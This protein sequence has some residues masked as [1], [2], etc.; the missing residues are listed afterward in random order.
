MRAS[1]GKALLETIVDATN[2]RACWS[3]PKAPVMPPWSG[4]HGIADNAS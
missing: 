4:Q 2:D 3:S 1:A